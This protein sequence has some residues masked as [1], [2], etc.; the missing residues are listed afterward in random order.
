MQKY[1]MTVAGAAALTAELKELKSVARPNVIKAIAEAR[2]HGDLKENAEYHAAREE[3]SFIEGRIQ[4]L[5]AKL[6][7]AQ[8]IDPS[9]M[10]NDG[11]V[12]FGSTV[13]IVNVKNDEELTYKIVGEDEV[14][15]KANKISYRSPIGSALVGKSLDDTISVTTPGGVVEYEIINV[16]Y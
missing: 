13:T 16:E 3:Q 10:V 4:D 12:I 15:I 6:S 5:E 9:T 1:P 2:A 14:D 7:N 11:K 8:I